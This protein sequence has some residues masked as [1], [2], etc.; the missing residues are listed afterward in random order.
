VLHEVDDAAKQDSSVGAARVASQPV[1]VSAD[2]VICLAP[3]MSAEAKAVR[4]QVVF[5]DPKGFGAHAMEFGQFRAR[6]TRDLTQGC[7][8]RVVQRAGC[9]CADLGKLIEGCRHAERLGQRF[10]I[11]GTQRARKRRPAS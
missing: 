6:D 5:N 1:I 7:V 11:T 10:R 2:L 8:A 9:R 3:E 4:G